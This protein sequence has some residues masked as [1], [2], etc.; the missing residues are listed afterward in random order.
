MRAQ[1]TEIQDAEGAISR[2]IP[3]ML[4]LNTR[5]ISTATVDVFEKEKNGESKGVLIGG[6]FE[7]WSFSSSPLFHSFSLSSNVSKFLIAITTIGQG[8]R[9]TCGTQQY[10]RASIRICIDH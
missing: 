7:R 6:G 9:G 10:G 5:G 8:C 1:Q 3:Q 2:F 4:C